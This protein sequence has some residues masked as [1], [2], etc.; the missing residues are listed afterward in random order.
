[1]EQQEP[2]EPTV[3]MVGQVIVMEVIVYLVEIWLAVLVELV[4]PVE[5]EQLAGQVDYIKTMLLIQ[6]Q[7]ELLE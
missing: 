2:M 4:E 3:E 6:A 5:V 7:M 1:M